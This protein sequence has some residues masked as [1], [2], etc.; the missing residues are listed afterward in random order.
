M[1]VTVPQVVADRER[2][3]GHLR[4]HASNRVP[5]RVPPTPVIPIRVNAAESSS[6]TLKL[7]LT[8]CARLGSFIQS[9]VDDCDHEPLCQMPR[10]GRFLYRRSL[11]YAGARRCERGEGGDCS[12]GGVAIPGEW[13]GARRKRAPS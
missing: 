4:Q 3:F 13:L 7:N 8:A 1:K 11:R 9:C 10:R 2:M 12:Q 6:L 5:K